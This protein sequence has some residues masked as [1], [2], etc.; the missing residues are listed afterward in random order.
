MTFYA[1]YNIISK[2][3]FRYRYKNNFGVELP[4]VNKTI[5]CSK[6]IGEDAC[7]GAFSIN[8]LDDSELLNLGSAFDHCLSLGTCALIKQYAKHFYAYW[9]YTFLYFISVQYES[10]I[11]QNNVFNTMSMCN[12]KDTYTNTLFKSFFAFRFVISH[13]A[14]ESTFTTDSVGESCPVCHSIAM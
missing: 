7:D 10:C 14:I 11:Y 5:S 2:I 9:F 4:F 12:V 3:V 1:V 13:K 6:K 8:F